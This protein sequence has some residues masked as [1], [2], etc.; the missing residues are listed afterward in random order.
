MTHSGPERTDRLMNKWRSEGLRMV[1]RAIISLR[2]N[3]GSRFE[4]EPSYGV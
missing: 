4:E 1:R 3:L 2:A